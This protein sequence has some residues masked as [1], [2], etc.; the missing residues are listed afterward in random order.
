[1]I[2]EIL[3]EIKQKLAGHNTLILQAPPGAGKSTFLPLQLLHESWLGEKKILMLEPRRLA[4]KTV[5]ARLASQLNEQPGE[6]VGYRIRFE[7]KISKATQLE[8]LTEG[9]L[10]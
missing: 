3:D 7:N 8:I 2:T 9:I 6:K 5:A 4:A 1:P 10:T